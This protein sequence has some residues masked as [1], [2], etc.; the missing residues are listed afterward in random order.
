[1]SKVVRLNLNPLK[2][3]EPLFI[4]DPPKQEKFYVSIDEDSGFCNED[5]GGFRSYQL[6]ADGESL[7]ELLDSAMIWE[8]DQ[9]GG[10][11]EGHSI[12][13][14]RNEVTMACETMIAQAWIK[15]RE[16]RA[17]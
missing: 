13:D 14:Y 1:M 5:E 7:N 3:R 11:H 15:A 10:D 2:M 6:Q 4:K 17:K 16:K 8:V 9:D 12:Y